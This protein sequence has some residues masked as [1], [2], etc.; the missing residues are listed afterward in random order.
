MRHTKLKFLFLLFLA[1]CAPRREMYVISVVEKSQMAEPHWVSRYGG[2]TFLGIGEA[3]TMEAANRAALEDLMRKIS[4]EIG[5]ELVATG[6]IIKSE[7]ESGYVERSNFQLDALSASFLRDIGRRVTNSYWEHCRAQTGK[8]T[9]NDFY[10]YYVSAEISG[11][12]VDTLRAQT[13][14]ENESRQAQIEANIKRA[15]D[16]LTANGSVKPMDA[17]GELATAMQTAAT[18]FYN[19]NSTLESLNDRMI[20]AIRSLRVN[21]LEIYSEVRPVR[22]YMV[23]EV[24]CNGKPAEDL[25]LRFGLTQGWGNIKESAITDADGSARCDVFQ[26]QSQ[27]ADNKISASL[28][29]TDL[30]TR[31]GGIRHNSTPTMKA[32][33]DQA[34]NSLTRTEVFSTQSKKARVTSG[35]IFIS[36]VA[37]RRVS[38]FYRR[39]RKLDVSMSLTEHNGRDVTFD[40]YAV[41]VDCWFMPDYFSA[42]PTNDWRSGTYPLNNSI[43]ISHYSTRNITLPYNEPVASLINDLKAAHEYGMKSIAVQICLIG[44]DDAGNAIEVEVNSEQITWQRLF[45]K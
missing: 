33:I 15:D 10:R 20:A 37:G 29:M 7:D 32:A 5:V 2:G 45:E 16:I 9:F 35:S 24:L 18:L 26:M 6:E 31:I 12:F 38:L 28:D 40:K 4:Q 44:K 43:F 1:A 27:Q 34:I 8:K 30:L 22:H 23:F 42:E 41:R 36:D 17:F 19:R 25:K 21:V 14:A 3:P 11:S 13:H 39:V